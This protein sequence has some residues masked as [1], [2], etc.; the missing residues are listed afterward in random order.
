MLFSVFVVLALVLEL[1][2]GQA[3]AGVSQERI[4]VSQKRLSGRWAAISKENSGGLE[5][6][7]REAVEHR[8]VGNTLLP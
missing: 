7:Y 3:A 4:S 6:A 1:Q 5:A 2:V 8:D